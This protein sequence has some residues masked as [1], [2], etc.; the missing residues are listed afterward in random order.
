MRSIWN[1][2]TKPGFYISLKL[3]TNR[4]NIFLQSK[5]I[6]F[7]SI[8]TLV[9]VSQHFDTPFS[10]MICQNRVY[11]KVLDPNLCKNRTCLICFIEDLKREKWHHSPEN[12]FLKTAL[13]RK[14]IKNKTATIDELNREDKKNMKYILVLCME[15]LFL[16]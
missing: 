8:L 10:N 6:D 12:V 14:I 9:Q 15:E 13:K 11:N 16:E 2:R 5:E 1:M 3:S 4:W 7:S